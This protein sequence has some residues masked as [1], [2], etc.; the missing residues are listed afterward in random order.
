MLGYMLQ[1]KNKEQLELVKAKINEVVVYDF[2]VNSSD[3][4]KG[5][6]LYVFILYTASSVC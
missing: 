4:P 5:S 3:L 1:L 6:P 2:P